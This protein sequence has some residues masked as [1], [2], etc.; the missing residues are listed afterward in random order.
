MAASAAVF[1]IYFKMV[2]PRPHINSFGPLL[3]LALMG[4]ETSLSWLAVLSLGLFIMG[5]LV[6]ASW[7]C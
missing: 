1:A 5:E 7:W 6:R 3:T 4:E 2:F